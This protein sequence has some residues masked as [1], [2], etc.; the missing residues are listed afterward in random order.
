MPDNVGKNPRYLF[1]YKLSRDNI[2]MPDNVGGNLNRILTSVMHCRLAHLSLSIND[3]TITW[4]VDFSP[5]STSILGWPS[6]IQPY[7][8]FYILNIFLVT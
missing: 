3:L 5:K 6:N 1:N 8:S 7:L 2:F 4:S